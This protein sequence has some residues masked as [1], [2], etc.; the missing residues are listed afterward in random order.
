MLRTTILSLLLT[1]LIVGCSKQDERTIELKP[2]TA[3]EIKAVQL[4]LIAGIP[5]DE[6]L[7]ADDS[8]QS[9]RDRLPQNYLQGFVEAPEDYAH[10]EGRKIQVFYYGRLEDG[11]DPIVFFNGGP[12]ADSHSS[13]SILEKMASAKKLSFIYID[14]RGNGCSDAF[15]S[16]PTE[17]NVQRLTHYTSADI[18]RDAELAFSLRNGFLSSI[19]KNIRKT[20]MHCKCCEL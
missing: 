17:E 4:S 6:A 14:Q 2:L 13:Y 18:V 12:A 7:E 19:S 1:S 15:P 20:A 3:K 8:C 5:L 9:F 16:E 11:K 10:P